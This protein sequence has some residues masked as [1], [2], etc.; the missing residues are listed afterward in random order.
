MH[1]QE[2]HLSHLR[3]RNES[4]VVRSND[5]VPGSQ[6]LCTLQV[7]T[8]VQKHF[9]HTVRFNYPQQPCEKTTLH[10]VSST[11]K[12]RKKIYNLKRDKSEIRV[13]PCN[14]LLLLWGANIDIQFV[15]A[16]SQ[17]WPTMSP[18]T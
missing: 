13:N 2:N 9:C 17:L 1:W 16:A 7:A 12:S 11:L 15:A 5:E 4:R 8:H 6:V 18:A 3:H 14:P 10:A